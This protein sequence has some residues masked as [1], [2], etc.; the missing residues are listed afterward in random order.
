M[1]ALI[2]KTAE[3]VDR[4]EVISE[5]PLLEE[6]ADYTRKVG[7]EILRAKFSRREGNP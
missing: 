5:T 7:Y 1:R 4:I 6:E 3:K 2:Q